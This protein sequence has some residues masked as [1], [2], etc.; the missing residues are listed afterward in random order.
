MSKTALDAVIANAR[1]NRVRASGRCSTEPTTR[2]ASWS[3][4]VPDGAG[5]PRRI[6][7]SFFF[8]G[9]PRENLNWDLGVSE[10]VDGTTL[11]RSG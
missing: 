6:E 1:N 10:A 4:L 9:S 8:D 5:R 3:L 7:L 11:A 2:T